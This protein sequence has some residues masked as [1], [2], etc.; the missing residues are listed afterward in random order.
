MTS[1]GTY[2][3]NNGPSEANNNG[4]GS[5]GSFPGDPD[6]THHD[7]NVKVLKKEEREFESKLDEYLFSLPVTNMIVQA[8]HDFRMKGEDVN[9][10]Y[11]KDAALHTFGN[12][13]LLSTAVFLFHPEPRYLAYLISSY[14][15]VQFLLRYIQSV[16][17]G[18]HYFFIDFCYFVSYLMW[19]FVFIY[20]KNITFYFMVSM[21][22]FCPLLNYFIIFTPELKIQNRTSIT[23]F[24]MHYAP[25]LIFWSLRYYN[26]NDGYFL[27]SAE[28]EAYI[29]TNGIVWVAI[30]GYGFYCIW[31]LTY[32]LIIFHI[33]YKVITENKYG[34]L[35]ELMLTK[36]KKYNHILNCMGEKWT[37]EVFMLM[38]LFNGFHGIVSSMFMM[39][40][41]SVSVVMLILYLVRPLTYSSKYYF[42]EFIDSYRE[43]AKK[44]AEAIREK[45]RKRVNEGDKKDN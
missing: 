23:S 25:S 22:A 39:K 9:F 18:W 41:H 7:K 26:K 6:Q 32:Y 34:H 33:R 27:T 45:S 30:L 2:E 24:Y 1:N 28:I 13:L 11:K 12:I 5:N 17:E 35:L 10:T 42:G 3:K 8:V 20:P 4:G 19:V 40:Y 44:K 38:H 37:H 29:D 15:M 31:A 14:L 21:N 43:K 16:R 36:T